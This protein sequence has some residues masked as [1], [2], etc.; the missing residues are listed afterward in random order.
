MMAVAQTVIL[1]Q[2]GH[3]LIG[4]TGEARARQASG[5]VRSVPEADIAKSALHSTERY[6][7]DD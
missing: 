6:N 1:R 4:E 3:G 7:A 5:L 2:A